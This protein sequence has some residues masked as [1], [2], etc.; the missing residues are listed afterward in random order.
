MSEIDAEQ[1][2]ER[3]MADDRL[4]QLCELQKTGDEV[5]DVAPSPRTSTRTSSRCS[6]HVKGMA[7]ATRYCAIF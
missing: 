6:T 5:L 2:L 3:L 7:R 1:A 4:V